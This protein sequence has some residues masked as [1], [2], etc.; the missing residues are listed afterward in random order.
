[1]TPNNYYFIWKSAEFLESTQL[2]DTIFKQVLNLQPQNIFNIFPHDAEPWTIEGVIEFIANNPDLQ[3]NLPS[4]ISPAIKLEIYS[5]K[6]SKL[7]SH[8]KLEKA[9]TEFSNNDEYMFH[10]ISSINFNELSPQEI[11]IVSEKFPNMSGSLWYAFSE[12]LKSKINQYPTPYQTQK[13]DN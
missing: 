6:N 12:V 4:D 10:L 13:G 3:R 8:E 9:F 1:M 7:T 11:R 5:H 2:I